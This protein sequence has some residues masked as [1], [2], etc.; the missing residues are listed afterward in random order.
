MQAAHNL[1]EASQHWLSLFAAPGMLVRN[2]KLQ[3]VGIV[4]FSCQFGLLLWNVSLC[5]TGQRRVITLDLEGGTNWK[6]CAINSLS[7][8]MA[9]QVE[10]V[11]LGLFRHWCAGA[12]VHGRSH[13]LTFRR[14]NDQD[15]T[16]L[17]LSVES[18]FSGRLLPHASPWAASP[19]RSAGSTTL[20]FG[21]R[22]PG[23]G[24]TN[25]NGS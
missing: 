5:Q 13:A 19:R 12:G 8:W 22:C 10:L 16:L 4:V 17:A 1:Q 20:G 9:V 24:R 7:G 2:P 18:A 11:P 21:M 3:V 6:F 15:M 23:V 14:A 25:T